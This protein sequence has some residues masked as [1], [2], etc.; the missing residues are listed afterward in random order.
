M[1]RMFHLYFTILHWSML[2]LWRPA[3][4]EVFLHIF[5]Y[6]HGPGMLEHALIKP[7]HFIHAHIKIT[8]SSQKFAIDL[9]FPWLIIE[10]AY[11]SLMTL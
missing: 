3:L 1:A 6:F 2:L 4:I 7:A 10:A 5:G 11:V 9:N 8:F